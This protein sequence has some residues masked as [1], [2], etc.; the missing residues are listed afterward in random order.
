M[1][2]ATV[3]VFVKDVARMRAFYGGV[4][5][6]EVLEEQHGWVL[7]DGG[8]CR[9]ALHAIP[10]AIA[11]GITI[12]DPPRAREDTAV[13]VAFHAPDVAAARERLAAAGVAMGEVRTFGAVSFCDGVD[14]EGNVFQ[15]SS[16]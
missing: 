4:L 7:L 13:K 15:I 1:R 5:G 6:L 2:V 16:R 3:I 9:L 14:P 11:R 8:G 10:E 12:E